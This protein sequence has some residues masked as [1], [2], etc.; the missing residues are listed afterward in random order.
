[1]HHADSHLQTGHFLIKPRLNNH[2]IGVSTASTW[3]R[4]TVY[5]LRRTALQEHWA[6]PLLPGKVLSNQYIYLHRKLTFTEDWQ[7]YWLRYT[8]APMTARSSIGSNGS[9]YTPAMLLFRAGGQVGL[10]ET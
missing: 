10:A 5:L 3:L 8:Q 4:R 2:S 9:R 1:M 7:E 6:L